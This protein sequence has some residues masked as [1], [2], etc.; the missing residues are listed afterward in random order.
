MSEL[1]LPWVSIALVGAVVAR[2]SYLV[3]AK[4]EG[5]DVENSRRLTDVI[6]AALIV[7]AWHPSLWTPLAQGYS[8]D[9]LHNLSLIGRIGLVLLTLVLVVLLISVSMVKSRMLQQMPRASH[10]AAAAIFMMDL[11]LTFLLFAAAVTLVPQVYYTY[12]LLLFDFLDQQ[13]IIKP[14][15]L[16]RAW[17]SLS[18]SAQAGSSS[19]AVGFSGWWLMVIVILSWLR[20]AALARPI[21]RMVVM[22]LITQLAWY[23]FFR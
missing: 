2:W 6:G 13:W 23:E 17:H 8:G 5:N 3:G 21:W 4:V 16:V 18:M 19:H 20:H 7:L 12:Y 22:V 14:S 1:W 15:A 11:L 9:T 10:G